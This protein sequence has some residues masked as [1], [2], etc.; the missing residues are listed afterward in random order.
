MSTFALV[1]T[2]LVA[3]GDVSPVVETPDSA[4][5]QLGL[6]LRC[7]VCQ[8]MPIAESPS[9]MAQDM[10]RRVRAMLTEGKSEQEIMDYFVA[11]YGEWV[12]LAPKPKGANLGLWI[13]PAV[14]LVV[15]VFLVVVFVRRRVTAPPSAPPAED[16][17][18]LAA[19]RRELE[20]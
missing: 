17:P 4:A 18:Y 15:G 11:R 14:A 5:H 10:M 12:L 7:P 1:A 19:V 9:E 3:Q 20:K 6:K 2:L 8:G 16:D 13:L